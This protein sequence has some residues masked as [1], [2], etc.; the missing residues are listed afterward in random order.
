M[1]LLLQLYACD[2]ADHL[3]QCA[4]VHLSLVHGESQRQG[5]RIEDMHDKLIA[6]LTQ[7]ECVYRPLPC[8]H[9]GCLEIFSAMHVDAHDQI[10]PYKLVAC[11]QGCSI[12]VRRLEMKEHMG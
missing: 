12:E 1:G 6:A 4:Y 3:E 2:L 5:K 9:E 7:Q 11:E 8:R 10:C